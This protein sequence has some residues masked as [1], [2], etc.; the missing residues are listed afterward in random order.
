MMTSD[1]PGSSSQL[2]SSRQLYL[3]RKTTGLFL[4]GVALGN[5]GLIAALTVSTLAAEEIAGTATWSGLPSALSILGT[6]FGTT[7]LAETMQRFGRRNGLVAGYLVAT[8]GATAAVVALLA[9]SLG[10][11]LVAT[12]ALGLGRSGDALS[13]YLVADLYPLWRRASAI[14]WIVWMGTIGAVLGPNSLDPAGRLASGFGLPSLS[15]AFLVTMGAYGIVAVA[16]AAL[17]RPDPATLIVEEIAEHRPQVSLRLRSLFG[18]A[19]VRVALAVLVV[20]HSVMVLIMTMT[21]LYLKLAGHGL[22]AIGLVMS[23]H[24]L[25]MFA[26]SPLTGRLVDRWGQVPVILVGQG[27]LLIAAV[28]ALLA[29][30]ADVGWVALALFLLGLGWNLGFVAGSALLSSGIDIKRRPRLQGV[31][32]SLVWLAAALASAASGFVL[33]ALGYDALCMI[34][35]ALLAIPL[36]TLVRARGTLRDKA[37]QPVS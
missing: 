36:A 22:K 10:L 33:A 3:R 9:G 24:I 34:G 11:L 18:R 1:Q 23:S 2:D 25:G 17:L 21:P 4:G 12:F 28:A 35:L 30:V 6:A 15:G 26:L 19:N 29:P 14:G 37:A 5:T 8:A 32:D 31:T 13:R 7:L 27:L 20:G 16:Y